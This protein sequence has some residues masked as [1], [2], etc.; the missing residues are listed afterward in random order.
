VHVP[1]AE[2]VTT[3]VIVASA[4]DF[5]ISSVDGR[6]V[7]DPTTNDILYGFKV[8]RVKFDKEGEYISRRCQDNM[9]KAMPVVRGDDAEFNLDEDL[10]Y[11]MGGFFFENSGDEEAG[12][13]SGDFEC[14]PQFLIEDADEDPLT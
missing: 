12:T 7:T 14:L 8:V 3:G 4:L 9:G 10:E 5:A 11:H 2:L 13:S 1:G 6:A